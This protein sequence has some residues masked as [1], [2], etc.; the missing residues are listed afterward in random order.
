MNTLKRKLNEF[1]KGKVQVQKRL[2][3]VEAELDRRSRKMLPRN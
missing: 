2:S 3:E 1:L